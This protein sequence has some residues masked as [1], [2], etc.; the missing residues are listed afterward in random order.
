ML[1]LRS[2]LQVDPEMDSYYIVRNP[3]KTNFTHGNKYWIPELSPSKDLF[4]GWKSTHKGKSEEEDFRDNYVPKFLNELIDSQKAKDKL[5]ELYKDS[6]R[7]DIQL[8][9]FCTDEK[10]CHR[11]IIGGLLKGA[12]AN[13]ECF[14]SYSKY[15]DIYQKIKENR[16]KADKETEE[17]M[18]R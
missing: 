5:N 12:G 18:E 16:K 2:V 6:F 1:Y 14:Q 17:D 4:M 11:S 3:G 10:T 7:K 8:V 15:W 9:C 13:I